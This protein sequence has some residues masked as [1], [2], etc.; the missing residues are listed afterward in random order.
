MQPT[1]A[2]P[3]AHLRPGGHEAQVRR[4]PA[5]AVTR[6]SPRRAPP[7]SL[8]LSL[9]RVRAAT[10]RARRHGPVEQRRG[11]QPRQP[12]RG[13]MDGR[14]REA[15][16][17]RRNRAALLGTVPVQVCQPTKNT[18]QTVHVTTRPDERARCGVTGAHSSV[19]STSGT[20][21]HVSARQKRLRRCAPIAS[22]VKSTYA[23][24]LT[25]RVG[26]PRAVPVG[27]LPRADQAVGREGVR[28]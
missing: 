10:Q 19:P 13:R 21:S 1:A 23:P 9:P 4:R 28:L 17:P 8:P 24:V 22:A 3:R 7:L 27:P 18:A 25:P 14:D 2:R 26:L 15:G 11:T 5:R 6:P 20:F 12:G 16:A